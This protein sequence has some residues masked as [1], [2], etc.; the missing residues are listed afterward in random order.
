MSTLLL[1]PGMPRL[2]TALAEWVA[3]LIVITPLRK[4][5]EKKGTIAIL[6][7][8]LV[9]Q[10]ALQ[11]WAETLGYRLWILGTVVN[12]FY[13]LTVIYICCKIEIR[14]AVYWCA[15]ALV[16]SEAVASLEWQ[17]Y[18]FMAWNGMGNNWRNAIL[19]MIVIYAVLF[20]LVF[21]LERRIVSADTGVGITTK[22]M[23]I[24]VIATVIIYVMSNIGFVYDSALSG[25]ATGKSL[26]YI[27]TL[28]DLCGYCILYILQNQRN[29]TYLRKELRSINVIFDQQYQQYLMY[30][31]NSEY[32]SRKC[33]DL[34]HQI[35]VIRQE[36]DREKRES[37]L[38]EMET[39][40]KTFQTDIVTGNKILDTIL[41]QKNS[42][43]IQKN[44]NFTCMVDGKYLSMLDTLDICSIFGNALDNAI[45]CVEKFEEKD[46][47]IIRLQVFAQNQFLI[48]CLENYCDNHNL[49][50]EEGLPGT[51]K[52]DKQ[53][54]GYGLKSIRYTAEKY[55]GSMTVHMENNWF[56]MRILLPM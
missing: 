22:E 35:N 18:C 54:H 13:M 45:E 33:H 51:T 38:E 37:Y 23:L 14:D 16:A 9:G 26:F 46:K 40:V 4:R 32:I 43:C 12:I 34:K 44:I 15:T 3:C 39:M 56:T 28:V 31:E 8:D 42:E 49:Q 30:K 7:L 53:N 5:W 27:R 29:E 19:F 47:R 6:I 55:G 17:I 36:T 2:F 11:Q 24:A 25:N 10:I 20:L 41:T 1:E 52:Q 21:L 50:L 48:I